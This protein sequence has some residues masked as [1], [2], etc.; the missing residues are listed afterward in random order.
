M[1]HPLALRR[2]FAIISHPDAG[3]TTITEKLL[4]HG[5]AIQLA[6]TVKARKSTRHATSDWMAIEKE[7]GISVT[8]SVMQFIYRDRVVNLL[9][10]PGHEDF[11]EDTYRTLTA[12]DSAL[13]VIDAA[14]GVEPRTI[15]LMEVCRLR[16]TPI[17]TFV[18][19]LDRDTRDPIDLLDEVERVLS[20]QCAPV[21]WPIGSGRH[22]RGVYELATDVVHCY[23]PGH[24]DRL[25]AYRTISGIESD[26]AARYLGDDHATALESIEL[27]R[28]A[29]HAFDRDAFRAGKLTPVIFGTAL[30]NFGVDHF[31][32][33]FVEEAPMPQPRE[34]HERVVSPDEA[35]FTG[36]VFKIQANMDPRHRDR[37]AFMRVCSGRYEPSMRMH[38]V[39]LDK[40][41]K[42]SDAV[43]F[44]AGERAQ[45]EEAFAGD[46]IGLH[47]HG[48]IQI[49]DTFTE[50]EEL[51]FKGVPNFAPELFR[52]VRSRDALK[53]KQLEKGLTQ[54]SEEGATQL[55]KP[56]ERNELILGAVGALQFDLVAFRLQD[57]YRADC[58]YEDAA[59]Y[60]A[61]WVYCDD[62]AK[63]EEFRRKHAAQLAVDGGGHLAYLAP[64]R[65]NLAL[66]QERWPAVRFAATREH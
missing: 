54:L 62:A 59:V 57:E 8:T 33:R 10:T 4:L 51:R 30:G 9:D 42:V 11:S 18:N 6:G 32:S 48:S 39:R 36:F 13:M 66:I 58:V 15:K 26:A 25:H 19:K 35:A 2:T 16:D 40:D 55:F 24:G 37:I 63:L 17:F 20:I 14:K 34:A 64:S 5:N 61:R 1:E 52:R 43:T 60:T 65:A 50:G 29:S 27:V 49:G 31:L 7:R 53:G 56:L 22:F 38:H 3:K 46:I 45:A 28:G 44:M 21:T 12:V 41:A 47:N 23:E